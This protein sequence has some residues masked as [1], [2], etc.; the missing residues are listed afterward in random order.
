MLQ[1]YPMNTPLSAISLSPWLRQYPSGS[2]IAPHAHVESQLLYADSGS[3]H[4]T[5]ENCACIVNPGRALLIPP[6]TEHEIR[7]PGETT[8]ASLY[9]DQTHAHDQPEPGSCSVIAVSP[10]MKQLIL[11]TIDRSADA[12]FSLSKN[13]HLVGLLFEE[14]SNSR[15]KVPGIDLPTDRR[16]KLVCQAVLDEP[17]GDATF[18]QFCERVGASGKTI[19]RVMRRELGLS[20]SEWR[21][22]ARMG[23]ASI[24]LKNGRRVTDVAFELGYANVSAF[25][26]AFRKQIGCSPT[27]FRHTRMA[28]F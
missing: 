5:T 25:C 22:H 21:Q 2:R 3:M 8:M 18:E 10:M 11:R 13:I 20:F 1:T 14:M 7:M 9:I 27:E 12:E 15:V 19:N 23:Y 16:A 6:D 4:V 17:G 28:H 26:Y 24:A